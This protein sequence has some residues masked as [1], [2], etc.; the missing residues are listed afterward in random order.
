MTGPQAASEAR[1]PAA[2]T[3][4]D[5]QLLHDALDAAQQPAGPKKVS[6]G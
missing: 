3:A 4:H 6:S 2:A 5:D 1:T